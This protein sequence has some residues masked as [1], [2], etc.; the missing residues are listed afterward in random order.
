MKVLLNDGLNKEGIQLFEEAGIQT[1]TRKRNLSSLVQEVEEF[2]A[3][4]VRSATQ[5]TPEVIRAGAE[6]KLK[7]IGRSGVGYEN[8]DLEAAIEYG[9]VVKNAPSGNTNAT[10][11]LA[12]GLMYSLSRN[13]ARADALSRS[14]FWKKKDLKGAELSHKTLGII[15]CGRIGQRLSELVNAYMTV[16]GYDPDLERVMARFPESRITYKSKD[17]VLAEADY[18]SIHTAGNGVV[19]GEREIALMKPSAYLINVARGEY[20]DER[21]LYEALKNGRL[22][23][24]GIDVY[25]REPEKDATDTPNFNSP[26][27]DLP[28]VVLTQHQGA[29]TDRAQQ[30][31]SEEIA[32]VVIDYLLR[33]DFSNAV[34]AGETIQAERRQVYPLFVHHSDVPG[35]FATI[36]GVLAA[37]K[38][39]IRENPSRQIGRNGEVVTVYLLHQQVGEGALTQLRGLDMVHSAKM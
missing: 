22:A 34:N 30:K 19:V 14:G 23:G 32:N 31:T 24:A 35:A 3:L 27:G 26:F 15:G 12:L 18:V 8:V 10:A 29:S 28:N 7:I 4:I 9:V 5:V 2:D 39:N 16:I 33:G 20:V 21:A 11:E 6:G 25:S 17:E 1:D 38:I 13:I 37:N 36:D